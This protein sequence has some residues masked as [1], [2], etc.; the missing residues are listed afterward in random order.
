MSNR[1]T[2][3]AFLGLFTAL[4]ITL[5]IQQKGYVTGLFIILFACIFLVAGVVFLVRGDRPARS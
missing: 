5:H 1:A 2:G 3:M 4:L